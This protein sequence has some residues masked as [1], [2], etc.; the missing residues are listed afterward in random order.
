MSITFSLKA[1]EKS[2]NSLSVYVCVCVLSPLLCNLKWQQMKS[3]VICVDWDHIKHSL[4][5][6]GWR[7]C[8][9]IGF[10]K[11]KTQ[12]L[13]LNHDFSSFSAVYLFTS[14][15]RY[16]FQ[17]Q[18]CHYTSRANHCLQGLI[19]AYHRYICVRIYVLWYALIFKVFFKTGKNAWTSELK[20]CIC[21]ICPAK[22][23]L[24]FNN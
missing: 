23:D 5:C 13:I 22:G 10:D 11:S 7:D 9:Y 16:L 19:S 14:R 18:N 6:K 20:C 1:T 2:L 24:L 21:V 15:A 17:M 12:T 4:V 3:T 8:S